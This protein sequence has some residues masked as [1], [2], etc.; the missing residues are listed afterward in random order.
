MGMSAFKTR[1]WDYFYKPQAF[2]HFL[3]V[4]VPLILMGQV[5]LYT[6]GGF[7]LPFLG[8]QLIFGFIASLSTLVGRIHHHGQGIGAAKLFVLLVAAFG[9]AG[10]LGQASPSH[11]WSLGPLGFTGAFLLIFQSLSS[12]FWQGQLYPRSRIFQVI[13]GVPDHDLR[14]TV[15]DYHD[16]AAFSQGNSRFLIGYL[17]MVIAFELI[18]LSLSL[19]ERPEPLVLMI[20]FLEGMGVLLLAALFRNYREEMELLTR[21]SRVRLRQRLMRLLGSAGLILLAA[22]YVPFLPLDGIWVQGPGAEAWENF[23][24][25]PLI[26]QQ[27][28][29]AVSDEVQDGVRQGE[30]GGFLQFTFEW[31]DRIG[32]FFQYLWALIVPFIP[33]TILL[34]FLFI[35][36]RYLASLQ[37]SWKALLV[38]IRRL[39]RQIGR[40]IRSFGK[41]SQEHEGVYG[42][43]ALGNQEAVEEWLK[44]LTKKRPKSVDEKTWSQV[45]QAFFRIMAWGQ[46]R[47]IPYRQGQTTREYLKEI[48]VQYPPLNTAL[49]T[50]R[51]GIDSVLFGGKNFQKGEKHAFRLALKD[52]LRFRSE[53][54][55]S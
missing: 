54:D 47:N 46:T 45:V 55:E 3:A 52:V 22:S 43:N 27:E 24:T 4:F 48:K 34:I 10:F 33:W 14:R 51:D 15:R 1:A 28:L 31:L 7:Y 2:H 50:L 40:W 37:W 25:P 21:G 20:L 23:E 26:E 18:L 53:V 6:F 29:Q 5:G 30:R 44:L 49:D 16:D 36:L 13:R 41:K 12:A 32:A 19:T 39:I 38:G 9:V 17:A 8:L 35:V 11:L 42:L